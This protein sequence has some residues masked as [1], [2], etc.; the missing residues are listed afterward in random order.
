NNVVTGAVTINSGTLQVGIGG[1]EGSIGAA[2]I[3]NN[4]ALIVNK[5]TT[6]T[7]SGTISG[8][9]TL[10]KQ[11]SGTLVLTASNTYSGA[12]TIDVGGTLQVGNGGTTGSFGTGGITDNGTLTFNRS[13]NVT[14]AGVI[15]GTGN[16]VKAGGGVLELTGINT[17]GGSTTVSGGWLKANEGAGLPVNSNLNLAGGILQT[18]ATTFTRN[19]GANAGEFQ[20][21]SGVSGFSAQGG[22]LTV[23]INNSG[24][25][26]AWGSGTF[27][28]LT[29][30]LDD[31]TAT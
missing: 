3:T 27:N 7:I 29:L 4:G 19:L 26:L 14:Y 17:Y 22:D 18:T 23:T 5:S 25:P 2:S 9:G 8:T 30:M 21:T 20:S 10:A 1:S 28:P 13:N 6:D 11:G 31:A 24:N 16:L 12:T 15:P